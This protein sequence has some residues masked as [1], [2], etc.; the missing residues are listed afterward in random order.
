M[1][2]KRPARRLVCSRRRSSAW[3]K[4]GI[5][6]RLQLNV[7]HAQRTLLQL[8]QPPD[9]VVLQLEPYDGSALARQPGYRTVRTQLDFTDSS[10][11]S[12]NTNAAWKDIEDADR[13]YDLVRS[14]Q[15]DWDDLRSPPLALP[16]G[17]PGFGDLS[18][19]H[20]PTDTVVLDRRELR[21]GQHSR[22]VICCGA[23][24]GSPNFYVTRG[25]SIPP[26]HFTRR[27]KSCRP[28]VTHRPM[29]R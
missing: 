24:Y 27:G 2:S 10:P 7:L 22:I 14:L 18:M 20:S 19:D 15:A 3:Q 8:K 9:R 11:S 16:P 13:E 5:W 6:P 23:L 1:G 29:C 28:P 25:S 12:Y 17:A 26:R 21:S 4:W